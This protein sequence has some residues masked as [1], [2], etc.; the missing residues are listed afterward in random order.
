[1]FIEEIEVNIIEQRTQTTRLVIAQLLYGIIDAEKWLN[2]RLTINHINYRSYLLSY[3]CLH[4]AL[5]CDTELF[6]LIL[7]KEISVSISRSVL[8]WQLSVLKNGPRS[9]RFPKVQAEIQAATNVD[10]RWLAAL[11]EQRHPHGVRILPLGEYRSIVDRLDQYRDDCIGNY[12]V[13][14]R[15]YVWPRSRTDRGAVFERKTYLREEM[16]LL[17]RKKFV[18]LQSST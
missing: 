4:N 3:Y 12:F 14:R 8:H 15:K 9:R 2:C 10:C 5:S 17:Y 13:V 16:K 7:T 11:A 1:M 6:F 18:Q